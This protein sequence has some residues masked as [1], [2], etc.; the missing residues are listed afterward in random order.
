MRSS[1][2]TFKLG[3]NTYLKKYEN[4]PLDVL[5]KRSD[6][7]TKLLNEPDNRTNRTNQINFF[8]IEVYK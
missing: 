7:I 6:V 4:E 2:I 5:I 1:K 3:I 8:D